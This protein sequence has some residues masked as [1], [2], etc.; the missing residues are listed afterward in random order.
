MKRETGVL[1]PASL[2]VAFCGDIILENWLLLNGWGL[3]LH[4]ELLVN[5][6]GN[7][8]LSFPFQEQRC[9]GRGGGDSMTPGVDIQPTVCEI[10]LPHPP[11]N[12]V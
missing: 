6:Q 1:L 4:F 3:S 2:L 8:T 7:H 10:Y 11:L 5:R 12:S 9:S